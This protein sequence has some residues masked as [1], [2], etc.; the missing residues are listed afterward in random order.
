MECLS[1]TSHQQQIT[2]DKWGEREHSARGFSFVFPFNSLIELYFIN[3]KIHLFSVSQFNLLKINLELCCELHSVGAE[4][5][6]H[7]H[8]NLGAQPP[9]AADA[10][11]VS[12]DLSF[13]DLSY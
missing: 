11:P 7:P 6:H 13:P 1:H 5:L 9:A 12:S 2:A 10:L 8:S 3:Y 4:C